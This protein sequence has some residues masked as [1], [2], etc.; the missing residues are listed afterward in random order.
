VFR[1]RDELAGAANLG[2]EI[3]KSLL[4]SRFLVVVCSPNSAR[5]R[6]VNDEIRYFKA[7]GRGG[8]VLAVI[9][10]GEPHAAD[11]P[12]LGQ[13]ECFPE[14]LKHEV[15]SDGEVT[16]ERVEPIA[17]DARPGKDG[18]RHVLL[19]LV[20]GIEG[21]GL[22]ELVRRDYARRIR[23]LGAVVIGSLAALAL[24]AW[25][26]IDAAV[27]RNEARLQ[28]DAAVRQSQIAFARQLAAQS[29]L[30]RTDPVRIGESLELAIRAVDVLKKQDNARSFEVDAALRRALALTPRA[31][32]PPQQIRGAIVHL[33]AIDETHLVAISRPGGDPE[34]PG[35]VLERF[36]LPDAEATAPVLESTRDLPEL[37]LLGTALPDP[38]LAVVAQ[39]R[40]QILDLRTGEIIGTVPAGSTLLTLDPPGNLLAVAIKDAQGAG[41]VAILELRTGHRVRAFE[42]LKAVGMDPF[43]RGAVA[44]A[45]SPDGSDLAIGYSWVDRTHN[46]RQSGDLS[47]V[48]LKTGVPKV[49]LH[50]SGSPVD[51]LKYGSREKLFWKNG[52]FVQVGVDQESKRIPLA[53]FDGDFVVSPS[54]Q[55]VATTDVRLWDVATGDDPPE[56][57]W[58]LPAVGSVALRFGADGEQLSVGAESGALQLWATERDTSECPTPRAPPV[59]GELG[60]GE[61]LAASSDGRLLAVGQ[62][63]RDRRASTTTLE[64]GFESGAEE[65]PGFIPGYSSVVQIFDRASEKPTSAAIWVRGRP[66]QAA[67][68]PDHRF[69]VTSMAP[70]SGLLVWEVATSRR[71]AQKK[72]SAIVSGGLAVSRDGSIVGFRQG[73]QVSLWRW[74]L[75]VMSAMPDPATDVTDF[76]FDP[77]S[78]RLAFIHDGSV[79]FWNY[80][81]NEKPRKASEFGANPSGTL[82]FSP[83]AEFLATRS[84]DAPVWIWDVAKAERVGLIEDLALGHVG[85]DATGKRIITTAAGGRLQ[86]RGCAPWDLS[87]L[88]ATACSR[89]RSLDDAANGGKNTSSKPPNERPCNGY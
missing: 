9:L 49:T 11:R 13:E 14:A 67:F 7:L 64:P 68:G 89:W 1:D 47:V 15:G 37:K 8:R 76:A 51:R 6:Y 63:K 32:S 83:N 39:E 87:M 62:T 20:A 45:F 53:D 71:L 57:V 38:F 41:R 18:K 85:F 54:E 61:L 33:A 82:A 25:L 4:A 78:D 24:V 34:A 86:V 29:E 36:R 2:A 55:Y 31:A 88:L 28:R 75:D 3:E 60:G 26:A 79:W 50:V 74:Q 58:R 66:I 10:D 52:N 56:E 65:R 77:Q 40:T 19:K 84:D 21:V 42:G 48:N 12:E 46:R 69:L 72:L 27:Q 59:S 73:G 35:L 22:D 81:K 44:A 5:S 80:E 23:F 43:S 30:A 16:S 70:A 17:A